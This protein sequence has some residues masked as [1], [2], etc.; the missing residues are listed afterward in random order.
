M[1]KRPFGDLIWIGSPTAMSYKGILMKANPDL[2]AE[3]AEYISGVIPLGSKV[4]DMGAGQGAFS[5]RL[6]DLGY[7]VLAVDQNATC[8][9]PKDIPFV[10]LDFNDSAAVQ[11]FANDH[12]SQFDVVIGM[13][14][15][16]H[17]ESPWDYIRLL[18]KLATSDGHIIIT[19]P[20]ADSWVCRWTHLLTGRMYHFEDGDY[21]TS[22]HINPVP[23]WELSIIS[24]RLGLHIREMRQL[25]RLPLI[26]LTRNINIM[27]GSIVMALITF[28]IKGPTKGDIIL[29]HAVKKQ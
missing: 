11:E 20:N 8:F 14:V 27:I 16:E 12:A 28:L 18:S 25:C 1:F 15:I 24:E 22:G 7:Q 3:L 6:N 19:T 10:Q 13:E 26:W 21:R 5:M 4:L 29:Y 23:S 17:V 2:H 9:L